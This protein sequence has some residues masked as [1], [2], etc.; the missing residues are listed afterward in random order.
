MTKPLFPHRYGFCTDCLPLRGRWHRFAMTEGVT[1]Q[2]ALRATYS[3]RTAWEFEKLPF[4]SCETALLA[5]GRKRGR[6]TPFAS[7]D[8]PVPVFALAKAPPRGRRGGRRRPPAARGGAG[9]GAGHSFQMSRWYSATERSEEKK[10][11]LAMFTSIFFAQ[12]WRSSKSAK[13]CSF[14]RI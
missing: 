6:R 3:A 9:A 12:A 11:A 4:R 7:L 8:G 10:P 1:S 2:V 14:T 5:A 13:S